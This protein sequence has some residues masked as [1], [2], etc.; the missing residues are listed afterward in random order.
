MTGLSPDK[1]SII[2]IGAVPLSGIEFD[3]E[4]FFSS[5]QPYTMI[6]SDSKKIHGLDGNKIMDAPPAEVVLPQ[7]FNMIRGRILVGQKPQLD[8]AFLWRA[9]K[10]VGGDMPSDWALDVSKYF[11]VAFLDQNYFSLDAMAK[12]IGLDIHRSVHNALDDAIITAK[13]FGKIIPL[14]QK[15]GIY[16]IEKLTGIG[17]AKMRRY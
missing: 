12:R 17:K 7:F 3:G 6:S 15:R 16:S 11:A 5:L 8:L 13:I 2:E 1:D 9:A 14:L 10:S 4:L